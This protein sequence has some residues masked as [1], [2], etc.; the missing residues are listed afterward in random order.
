M[1]V[2]QYTAFGG[3]A[4]RLA[5]LRH[6]TIYHHVIGRQTSSPLTETTL[7]GVSGGIG[8]VYALHRDDGVTGFR[9]DLGP[10]YKGR[11]GETL[12]ALCVRLGLPASFRQT[13][14]A[15]IADR[16]V[17][18]ALERGEPVIL[19]ADAAAIPGLGHPGLGD[20]TY[21]GVLYGIEG[22]GAEE[23][24]LLADLSPEPRRVPWGRLA[25]A[26]AAE[27]Y[28]NLSVVVG[29]PA[30]PVDLPKAIEGGLRV[31]CERMMDPPHPRQNHGLRA[32]CRLA[33]TIAQP[34]DPEGWPALF[35]DGPALAGALH[36]LYAAVAHGEAGVGGGRAAFA[37]FLREVAAVL[38]GPDLGE[39]IDRYDALA[40]AWQALGEAALPD[41]CPP[42]AE[43]RRL[44][45]ARA[46]LLR[47][48]GADAGAELD[49]LGERISA[50]DQA[51]R[52]DFPLDEAG[53]RALL[54]E[55]GE[56][57]DTL[58]S[59][60]EAAVQALKETIR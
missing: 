31:C 2:E 37:D 18:A 41:A 11:E 49:T 57:M 4:F 48:R 20:A 7:F 42:L 60:E 58:A 21:V 8:A 27:G 10:R 50:L 1:V 24:A 40:L 39:L 32:L 29:A 6:A 33:E 5:A 55:L 13:T 56:R 51:I 44:H 53:R 15:G 46:D 22:D 35:P 47:R 12:Q 34:G 54:E 23:I 26:R 52:A 43:L 9:L 59:D 14:D 45:E 17:R 3:T 19:F 30:A 38:Q 25:L 16:N 28:R 36:T